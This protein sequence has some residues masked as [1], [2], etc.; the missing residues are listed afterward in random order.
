MRVAVCG[1]KYPEYELECPHFK[2]IQEALSKM[3][4]D[5][6]FVDSMYDSSFADKVIEFKPDIVLYAYSD[7]VY[8]P[9]ARNK[10]K[11]NTDAK[12]I[13]WFGD[14]RDERTRGTIKT[15]LSKTIDKMFVSNKGQKKYYKYYYNLEA[16]YLP[17]ACYE[18]KER[19]TDPKYKE[20][21]VF[22]GQI[23]DVNWRS[24]R[25]K[26]VSDILKRTNGK[27]INS[28]DDKKRANIYRKMP[29]IYGTADV[30]LDIS[31]FWDVP[32]YTSNRS[33]IIPMCSGFCL[34][35]KYPDYDEFFKDKVHKVYFETSE[36][37]EK[38]VKYYQEHPKERE[39]IR[40]AGHQ[41]AL[42]NHTYVNRFKT[43]FNKI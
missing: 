18:I 33:W 6:I 9:W 39:E 26:I 22:I 10:I 36:E 27:Q 7:I 35:K 15:D 17:L 1:C 30:S 12:I 42:K 19:H 40:E 2:G 8:N 24:K 28:T 5:Y 25:A 34:T 14:Y 21:L 23:S 3:N 31:H 37:A 16:E 13:F 41:E 20:S 32:G 38:L 29:E 11:N 43:M 4:I